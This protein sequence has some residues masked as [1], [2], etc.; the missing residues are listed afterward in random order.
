MGQPSKNDYAWGQTDKPNKAAPFSTGLAQGRRG[1]P[2]F[3][4]AQLMS[5]GLPGVAEKP[6]SS[7]GRRGE[8]V[9]VWNIHLVE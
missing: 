5:D 3:F 9:T 2:S 6:P 7:S 4:K 8:Y 1:I